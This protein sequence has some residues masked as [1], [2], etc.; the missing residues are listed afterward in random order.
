MY[1]SKLRALRNAVSRLRGDLPTDDLS[2]LTELCAHARAR[3]PET[4][5]KELE[6]LSRWLIAEAQ[7]NSR[8]C[9]SVE[10]ENEEDILRYQS[11]F[12]NNLLTRTTRT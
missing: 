11:N 4:Y 7:R 12:E 6:N 8:P 9:Y 1:R 2:V 10:E 3:T 5:Q